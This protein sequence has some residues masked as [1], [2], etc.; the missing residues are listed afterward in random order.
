MIAIVVILTGVL[1]WSKAI[2]PELSQPRW[3]SGLSTYNEVGNQLKELSPSP[4]VVA[5]NNPPGFYL[6]TNLECVVIPNGTVDTLRDVVERHQVGWVVLDVNRPAG[7]AMLYDEPTSIQ[8]LVHQATLYDS[9]GREI[10]VL[11]VKLE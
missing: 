7:L 8:W 11:K 4:A 10:F 1:F 9:E 6:A 2:G 5:V 3:Q